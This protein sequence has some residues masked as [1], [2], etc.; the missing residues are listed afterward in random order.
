VV[1]VKHIT[2]G[3]KSLLVG[4][5]VAD[6]LLEY[7]AALATAAH[8]D[9]V[10][11]HAISSDGN[12]VTA[13]FLLGPGVTMMA[14]SA[15]TSIPE[16]DNADALEYIRQA[17]SRPTVSP[18]RPEDVLDSLDYDNLYGIDSEQPH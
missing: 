13:T 6:A 3:D 16:P 4:D 7:A 10:E 1:Q 9:T 17:R 2:F 15:H 11:I 14:E 5:E 12:E 8:G 18:A